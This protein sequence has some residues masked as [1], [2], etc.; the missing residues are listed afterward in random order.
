[1]PQIRCIAQH[2]LEQGECLMVAEDSLWPSEA[3]TPDTVSCLME[4]HAGKALWLGAYLKVQPRC[5]A[6]ADHGIVARSLTPAGAKLFCGDLP[7]W[8]TVSEVFDV[9]DK[10][11]STDQVFQLLAGV[12]CLDVAHPFLAATMPHVSL[13]TRSVAA[14]S[15]ASFRANH[16]QGALLPL[17][18]NWDATL[19]KYAPV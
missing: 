10:Y 16:V 8:Q 5:M 12:K 9:C 14:G 15:D 18:Q 2:T 19:A 3:L 7:F 4:R 11:W 13:R 1:M 6:V 17:P